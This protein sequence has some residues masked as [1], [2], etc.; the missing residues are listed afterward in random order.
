MKWK[1]D[2]D[3]QQLSL[4]CCIKCFWK[5]PFISVCLPAVWSHNPQM[6]T[7]LQTPSGTTWLQ[8]TVQCLLVRTVAHRHLFWA[9]RI[10][11]FL[12]WDPLL[13]PPPPPTNNN[14]HWKKNNKKTLGPAHGPWLDHQIHWYT[15]SEWKLDM[16][17]SRV[18]LISSGDTNSNQDSRNCL[19]GVCGGKGLW[20][21]SFTRPVLCH[22]G[23]ELLGLTLRSSWRV[24]LLNI[25][26][27]SS[28]LGG[29]FVLLE[30]KDH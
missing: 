13:P 27:R 12:E 19:G 17:R 1:W 21:R 2:K 8:R 5:L 6:G 11:L 20:A 18:I 10:C 30:I 25:L 28:S 15:D 16:S 9:G 3:I 23:G 29:R 7:C 24:N 14:R 4:N 22:L 26:L